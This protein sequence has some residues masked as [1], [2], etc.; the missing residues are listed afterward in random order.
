MMCHSP[1]LTVVKLLKKKKME[2]HCKI[3]QLGNEL[4]IKIQTTTDSIDGIILQNECFSLCIIKIR[5]FLNWKLKWTRVYLHLI[6]EIHDATGWAM[7]T[8]NLIHFQ[9]TFSVFPI[10][11]EVVRWKIYLSSSSISFMVIKE[12]LSDSKSTSVRTLFCGM[13]SIMK[14]GLVIDS[15]VDLKFQFY[16]DI[17]F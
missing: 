4:S 17:Q 16:C 15:F 8:G 13:M 7:E 2:M 6:D 9:Q 1:W 3:W 5:G 12:N 10:L 11:W 14:Y